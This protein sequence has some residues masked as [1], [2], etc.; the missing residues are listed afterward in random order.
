MGNLTRHK[1]RHVELD[2]Q[3]SPKAIPTTS[4]DKQ[5]QTKKNVVIVDEEKRK[6]TDVDEEDSNIEW[7]EA[8]SGDLHNIIDDVT[9]SEKEV[10]H[11]GK[12]QEEVHVGRIFRK[13]TVLLLIF[14]PKRKEPFVSSSGV[15]ARPKICRLPSVFSYLAK[16]TEKK[17]RRVEWTITKWKERDKDIEHIV[18]IEEERI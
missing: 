16:Q 6:E 1:K 10:Q 9:E 12:D 7:K 17:A 2:Q 11:K 13:P 3:V 5:D 14:A 4:T 18:M 15:P 8:D